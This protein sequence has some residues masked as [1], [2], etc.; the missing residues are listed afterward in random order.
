MVN[1]VLKDK[2]TVLQRLANQKAKE[3]EQ[4]EK[5][6]RLEKLKGQVCKRVDHSS[7]CMKCESF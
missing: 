2:K 4:R 7:F 6:K 3:E 5:E 1:Y